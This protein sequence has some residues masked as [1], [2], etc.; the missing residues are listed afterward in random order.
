MI[1]RALLAGI[2]LVTVQVNFAQEKWQSLFNGKDLSGWKIINGTAKY[3]IDADMIA[4]EAVLNSPNSS[5]ATEK[6]YSDFI[7]ELEVKIDSR[8]NSG[9]Q[10]RSESR[11]DYKNGAVFGYQ[12]KIDPSQRTWTGGILDEAR[13]GWLYTLDENPQAKTALKKDDWNKIRIEA[14]G[15]SIRTWVNGIACADLLDDMTKEG[16]I[17]LQV[18][19]IGTDKQKEGGKVYFKNIRIL[20][21]SVERYA[22]KQEPVIPQ[23]NFVPNTLSER[24]K[25]EGWKLLWDGKTGAGWK[26]AKLDM[27]PERGWE[28]K[29]GVLK[30]LKSEGAEARNG[31]D[32]I[33]ADKYKNFELMVEFSITEG[34]NSGVKYFVDPE[35]NK[36]TGSA[37]GC[38]FQILDDE[39]HPDAKLGVAGN[40]TLSSLYDLITAGPKKFSGIGQWNRGRIIVKDNNVEHWL[41]GQ[42]TVEYARGTQMWRALVAYS[43]YKVWPGFGEA[44]E[45]HILLQDH[46]DEVWFRNIKI[47]ELN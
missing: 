30:V 41:N 17:A 46:G 31:G 47:K 25:K 12:V 8:I 6:K 45:G 33:T 35:L 44:K 13:R 26:G 23:R 3:Y 40:R 20:T 19:S 29:D 21:E 5:L 42:K 36:G 9:I 34:A 15:N 39:K 32:I 16:F 11:P 14:L 27:F 37:I 7:L 4:G 24:E 22:S 2:L 1:R 10:V 38:E 28:I 18:H 43:K